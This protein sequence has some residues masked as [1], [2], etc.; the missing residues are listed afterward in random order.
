M[1]LSKLSTT[2]SANPFPPVCE[3][4]RKLDPIGQKL[5]KPIN[6]I[7]DKLRIP[8]LPAPSLD[9]IQMAKNG[10]N[11]AKYS[12]NRSPVGGYV[13]SYMNPYAEKPEAPVSTGLKL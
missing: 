5:V 6:K 11:T 12:V 2:P 13:R 9:P 10:H 8:L 7:H 3:A 4:I 1:S